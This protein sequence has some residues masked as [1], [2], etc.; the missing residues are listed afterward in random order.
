MRATDGVTLAVGD[1]TDQAQIIGA[2]GKP[3]GT[4]PYFGVGFDA[5]TPGAER[6]TPFRLHE[7]A[8]ASGPGEVVIDRA[9]AE[10][11]DYAVGERS[12]WPRA[13]RRRR[14][15]SPASPTSRT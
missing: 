4:G 15:P 13:A 5:K 11:Q 2:D 7:G 1:I 8:W 3:V 9:T 14:S 6:L 10:S 12:A